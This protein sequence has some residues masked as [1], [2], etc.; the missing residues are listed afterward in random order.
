MK[1]VLAATCIA[2]LGA[3]GLGAQA[4]ADEAQRKGKAPAATEDKA[5]SV[6]GCLRAGDQPDTFVLANVKMDAPAGEKATGTTGT[7]AIA[8]NATL[9]VIGAPASL[10]LKPHVGHTVMLTGMFVPQGDPSAGPAGT[11]PTP[12][13]APPAPPKGGTPPTATPTPPAPATPSEM[14]RFNVK[15]MK[16]V[17]E[18][19]PM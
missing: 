13:S 11:P 15:S 7:P 8:Q 16:H 4:P 1:R 12:P 5:V 17:S 18:K 10:D 2:A 3:V 19:C 9:R 6:T 14:Q